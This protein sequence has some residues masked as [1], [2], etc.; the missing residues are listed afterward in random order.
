MGQLYKSECAAGAVEKNWTARCARVPQRPPAGTTIT[1]VSLAPST[2]SRCKHLKTLTNRLQYKPEQTRFFSMRTI[3]VQ[4]AKTHLSRL[5]EDA[6]GGETILLAKHGKPLAQL[7]AYSP[8]LL[9]RPLGGF[10]G[11]IRIA[12]DF[13]ARD[14]RVE[15]L[16]HGQ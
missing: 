16:F 1:R 12:K 15:A 7:T 10:K 2:F 9:P 8:A 4:E 14:S 13:D 5:I 3:N 11:R 6:L